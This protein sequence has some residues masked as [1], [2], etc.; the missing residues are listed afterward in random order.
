VGGLG[1]QL[2]QYAAGRSL[3]LKKNTSLALDAFGYDREPEGTIKRSY[4][5]HLFNICAPLATVEQINKIAH[6]SLTDRILEKLAFRSRPSYY[7]EPFFHFDP[8]FF[9]S[10]ASTILEGYWQS[11]Q[12]FKDI[13]PTVRADLRL[14]APLSAAALEMASLIASR[15]SI[16]LHIRRGDFANNPKTFD[17]HGVCEPGYY[18]E[19]VRKITERHSDLEI[20]VF[21]DDMDWAKR[22]ITTDLPMTF[23]ND[24]GRNDY[25]D[26]YL[27]SLCKHNIIANSSFSWWGAWLNN[28]PGK[29]V[30]APARWFNGSDADTKDLLPEE[31]IKV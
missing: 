22:H 26:L 17:Y 27:M 2:F 24:A 23:V 9:K 12:Y 11:E 6:L 8:E 10:S 16:S 5:L 25:E 29:I 19:A 14:V 18:R 28:N 15:K 20:F 21:S 4:G 30:I 1:N 7:R 31:W 13:S 3:A